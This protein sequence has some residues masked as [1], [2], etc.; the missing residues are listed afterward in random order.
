MLVKCLGYCEQLMT[1]CIIPIYVYPDT[2]L[3][4]NLLVIAEKEN[5][6]KEGHQQWA[7]GKVRSKKIFRHHFTKIL[8]V[9]MRIRRSRNVLRFTQS[10]TALWCILMTQMN[11]LPQYVW[12]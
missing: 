6:P 1:P 5:S 11:L 9:Q 4:L 12:F 3:F 2:Q 8:I 7:I 10:L